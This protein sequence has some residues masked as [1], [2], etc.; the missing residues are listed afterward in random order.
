MHHIDALIRVKWG[1]VLIS[2]ALLSI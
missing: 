2:R 1:N